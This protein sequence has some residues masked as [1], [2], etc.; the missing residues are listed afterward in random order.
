MR[1]QNGSTGSSVLENA[2]ASLNE[3]DFE[4]QS[5]EEPI[6][7]LFDKQTASTSTF[8][9]KGEANQGEKNG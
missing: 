8:V 9:T 7:G 6:E 1:L 5:N 4:N 2:I 3:S